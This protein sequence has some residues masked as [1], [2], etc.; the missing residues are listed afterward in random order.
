MKINMFRQL[1]GV[2]IDLGV[3]SELV[4]NCLTQYGTDNHRECWLQY[5]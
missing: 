4:S 5:N 2:T 3:R 1:T